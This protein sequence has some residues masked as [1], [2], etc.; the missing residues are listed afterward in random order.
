MTAER[1]AY[2]AKEQQRL[3]KESGATT[4][5]DAVV[6]TVQKQLT[7]SGFETGPSGK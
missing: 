6:T 7:K 1:E 5:G 3:A 4:L 2:L